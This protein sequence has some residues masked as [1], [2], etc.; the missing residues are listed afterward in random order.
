M[1]NSLI[2]GKPQSHNHVKE[3][4]TGVAAQI[5]EASPAQ[6]GRG[7]SYCLLLW[8]FGWDTQKP[9]TCKAVVV[10]LLVPCLPQVSIFSRKSYFSRK[11]CLYIFLRKRKRHWGWQRT[12]KPADIRTRGYAKVHSSGTDSSTSYTI[13][14]QVYRQHFCLLK[15]CLYQK[16]SLPV[17][18]TGHGVSSACV[19]PSP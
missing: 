6:P 11:L 8:W 9:L 7:R 14:P 18:R 16:W 2:S 4:N 15:R 3:K 10:I 13:L 19:L 1:A 17:G 5:L 12:R